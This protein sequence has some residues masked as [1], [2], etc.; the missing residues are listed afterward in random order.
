MTQDLTHD[1]ATARQIDVV[2]NALPQWE[3][4]AQALRELARN[5]ERAAAHSDPR[6]L[7]RAEDLLATVAHWQDLLTQ[8]EAATWSDELR[9]RLETLAVSLDRAG[10]E[11][12]AALNA[13]TAHH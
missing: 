12:K 9:S 2:W 7:Q 4:E 3:E 11:A 10:N 1:E 6:T 13:L 8:W 5:S